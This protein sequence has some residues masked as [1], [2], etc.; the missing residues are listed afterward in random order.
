MLKYLFIKKLDGKFLKTHNM[1]AKT[2]NN[3]IGV[4]DGLV[5]YGFTLLAIYEVCQQNVAMAN[6]KFLLPLACAIVF[7]YIA[8][9]RIPAIMSLMGVMGVAIFWA[10]SVGEPNKTPVMVAAVIAICSLITYSIKYE[11][12]KGDD[13]ESDKEGENL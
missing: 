11:K 13:D 1:K 4:I 8:I 10:L 5:S 7:L 6:W 12:E 9:Q 2:K 3:I